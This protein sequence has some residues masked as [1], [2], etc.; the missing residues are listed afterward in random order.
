[1]MCEP[2]MQ[3]SAIK[4]SV[5]TFIETNLIFGDSSDLADDSSLLESGVLDSTSVLEVISFLEDSYSI[6]F[7][8]DELISDNFDSINRIAAFVCGKLG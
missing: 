3:I 8:D 2:L 5:R 7:D 6:S 1:M 4:A